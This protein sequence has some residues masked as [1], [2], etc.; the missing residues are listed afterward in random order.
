MQLL[1][2]KTNNKQIIQYKIMNTNEEFEMLDLK[3]RLLFKVLQIGYCE[4]FQYRII[5]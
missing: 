3:Q 4:V 1:S 5:S 2:V